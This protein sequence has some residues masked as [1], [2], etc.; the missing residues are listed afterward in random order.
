MVLSEGEGGGGAGDDFGVEAGVPAG[1]AG[2][3]AD[4]LDEED[5]GVLITVGADFDDFLDVAGGFPFVPNF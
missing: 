4:L 2:S 5:D 3:G 1:V